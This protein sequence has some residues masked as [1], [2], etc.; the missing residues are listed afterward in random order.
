MEFHEYKDDMTVSKIF[1]SDGKPNKTIEIDYDV[2]YYKGVLEYISFFY[3]FMDPYYDPIPIAYYSTNYS[4]FP[5][6]NFTK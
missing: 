2:E 3:D 6:W 1:D 5:S 4:K